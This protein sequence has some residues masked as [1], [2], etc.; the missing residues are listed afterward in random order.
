MFKS[1]S[2]TVNSRGSST[3][4]DDRNVLKLLMRTKNQLTSSCR[5]P[6]IRVSNVFCKDNRKHRKV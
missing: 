4:V 5:K 6:E 3:F 1:L 2:S